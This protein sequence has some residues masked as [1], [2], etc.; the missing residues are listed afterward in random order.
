M[1]EADEVWWTVK[2]WNGETSASGP[3]EGE[4][5]TA[6][7]RRR[8]IRRSRRKCRKFLKKD[9]NKQAKKNRKLWRERKSRWTSM[10]GIFGDKDEYTND[11]SKSK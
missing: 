9:K 1:V 5:S 7:R 6:E 3:F 11:R 8:Q 2:K 10:K 4:G